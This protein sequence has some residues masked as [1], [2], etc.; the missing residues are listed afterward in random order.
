MFTSLLNFPVWGYKGVEIAYLFPFLE[1]RDREKEERLL[2]GLT[3]LPAVLK[4]T[5]LLNM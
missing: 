4:F 3:P 5:S 2:E 1:K